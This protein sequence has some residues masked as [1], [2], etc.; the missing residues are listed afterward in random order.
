MVEVLFYFSN[1]LLEF[2]NTIN[3]LY[4]LVFVLYY[5]F[6]CIELRECVV[7]CVNISVQMWPGR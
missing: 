7:A 5:N 4:S 2:C 6:Y 1:D 3:K